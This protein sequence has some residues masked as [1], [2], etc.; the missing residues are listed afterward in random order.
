MVF[1]FSIELASAMLID[2]SLLPKLV[3]MRILSVNTSNSYVSK[4][5]VVPELVTATS[6]GC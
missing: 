2:P 1:Y 5:V 4:S 3:L 6:C